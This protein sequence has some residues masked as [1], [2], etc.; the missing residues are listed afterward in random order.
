MNINNDF[1]ERKIVFVFNLIIIIPYTFYQ[2]YTFCMQRRFSRK[3]NW[4]YYENI[5]I[6]IIFTVNSFS[7]YIIID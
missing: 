3:Q 2:V 7:M 6:M 5:L 4:E 1:Y